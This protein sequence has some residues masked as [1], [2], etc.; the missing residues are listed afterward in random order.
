VAAF[1]QVELTIFNTLGQR[2]RTLISET[3]APGSYSMLWDGRSSDGAPL[4]SGLYICALK[5]G[6]SFSA[7]KLVLLR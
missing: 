7:K 2:V 6:Q 3:R 5:S 1:G 4:A